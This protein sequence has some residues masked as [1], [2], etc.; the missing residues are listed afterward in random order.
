MLLMTR[1]SLTVPTPGDAVT[2]AG[3]EKLTVSGRGMS[4]T[5]DKTSTSNVTPTR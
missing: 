3:I 5:G 1:T 2:W 4:T